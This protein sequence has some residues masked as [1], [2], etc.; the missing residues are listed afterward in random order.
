MGA[1]LNMVTDWP[2]LV[3]RKSTKYLDASEHIGS[4]A[5]TTEQLV[6]PMNRALY[7]PELKWSFLQWD[8]IAVLHACS[9]K[10]STGVLSIPPICALLTQV[11]ND[12]RMTLRLLATMLSSHPLLPLCLA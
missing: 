10:S 12:S 5:W 4:D 3:P 8:H 6:I 1:K 2:F 7:M 9:H 11:R